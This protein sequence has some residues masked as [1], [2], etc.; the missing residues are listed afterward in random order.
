MK[1][2]DTLIK[3]TAELQKERQNV[4]DELLTKAIIKDYLKKNDLDPS[5]VKRY[6]MRFLR[7]Y[8]QLTLCQKCQGLDN[9]LLPN[10]GYYQALVEDGGLKSI[11]RPCRH[12]LQF[13]LDNVH[14][15]NY[16]IND[17]PDEMHRVLLSDIDLTKEEDMAYLKAVG[18]ISDWLSSASTKGLYLY[19]K[20]GT[21][22]TY[23]MACIAN[24]LAMNDK[25]VT[26][27]HM[28]KLLVRLKAAFGD[29]DEQ[30]RIMKDLRLVDLLVLDDIGAEPVTG[31]YRDEI[32]ATILNE[33]MIKKR[34][35]CFTSNLDLKELEVNFKYNQRGEVDDLKATRIMERIKMLADPL[36][37]NGKN[38]RN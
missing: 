9:C 28:P 10:V 2:I 15:K 6:P 13:E 16:W 1:R 25:T 8:E 19:G 17:V 33:R 14:L 11:Y 27:V 23:L 32:L 4:G 36:K 34:L 29:D 35:T 20:V 26:F 37:I 24:R 5:L 12:R 3:D 30:E 22:K 21:G 31:W 7:L 38:R 18:T